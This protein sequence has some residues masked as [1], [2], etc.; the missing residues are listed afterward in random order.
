MIVSKK[1]ILILDHKRN[2][3]ANESFTYQ[4]T[5]LLAETLA[6]TEQEIPDAPDT[7]V[8]V[9]VI[10]AALNPVDEQL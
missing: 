7:G 10:A 5:G 3:T 4:K 2:M 1:G 9:R 6:L 8:V